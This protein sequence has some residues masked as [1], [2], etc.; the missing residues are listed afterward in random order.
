MDQSARSQVDVD[1]A[2]GAAVALAKDLHIIPI[3]LGREVGRGQVERPCR[4]H[5]TRLVV[6]VLTCAVAEARPAVGE[7][8][9]SRS[10]AEDDKHLAR[11]VRWRGRVDW[12]WR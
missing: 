10:I 7:L 11:Y 6:A 2:C 12:R 1:W 9:V 8:T 4:A 3:P 5:V